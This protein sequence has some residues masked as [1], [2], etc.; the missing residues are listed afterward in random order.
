VGN[1]YVH[2]FFTFEHFFVRKTLLIKYSYAFVIMP[3]GFGT[4]DE[5]FET[6][7]LIQ[8]KTLIAFPVVLFGKEFY[9]EMW[10]AIL[11]MAE[12]GTISREDLDLVLYTDDMDEAM[13]HILKYIRANYKVMP[14]KPKWWLL[15]RMSNIV[16]RRD[17]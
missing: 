2:R 11:D 16:K 4:M 5:F 1:K 12:R 7:T 9:K 10:E 17:Q 13:E 15:E 6:L 14:Y 8:T 3:G